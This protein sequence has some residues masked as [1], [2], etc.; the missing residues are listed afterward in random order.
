MVTGQL[1]DA[2]T[3]G[4]VNSR[5]RQLADWTSRGLNNSQTEQ[6]A[7]AAGDFVCFVF[8]FGHLIVAVF[9]REY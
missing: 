7:D 5:I 3:R 4:L 6:L 9:L 8:D 1:E 2:P